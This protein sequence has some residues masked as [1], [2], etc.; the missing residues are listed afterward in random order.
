MDE[1][2]KALSKIA[3][4]FVAFLMVVSTYLLYKDYMKAVDLLIKTIGIFE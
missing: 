3:P 4:Y 1:L 2:K